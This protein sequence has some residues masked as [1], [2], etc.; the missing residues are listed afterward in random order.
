MG[1]D[2]QGWTVEDL[3][4][5]GFPVLAPWG[6][7]LEVKGEIQFQEAL[8]RAS[9]G[10]TVEGH[11]LPVVATLVA[12]PANPQDPN[13][14]EVHLGEDLV[15]YINREDAAR[16]S[17]VLLALHARAGVLVSCHATIVGGWRR[18][19]DEGHFG[20]WLNICPP[21]RLPF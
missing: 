16:W 5:S 14:V 8:E 7:S 18:D 1:E 15:G 20:I 13:A 17:P 9:G 21:E 11:H 3:L 12:Q 6:P 2:G 4:A 19:G 10:K